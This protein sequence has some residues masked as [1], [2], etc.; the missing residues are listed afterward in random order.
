MSYE[1]INEVDDTRIRLDTITER[2]G[3]RGRK[4]YQYH[5]PSA[6]DAR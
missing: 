3:Q 2:D 1:M 6:C 5:A 4:W